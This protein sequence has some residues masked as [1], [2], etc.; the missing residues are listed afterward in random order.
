[1]AKL[2]SSKS[3]G[4]PSR[5]NPGDVYFTVDTGNVYLALGDG[6]LFNVNDLMAGGGA[7]RVVGPQGE[8]GPRGEAGPKGETGERGPAGRDGRQGPQGPKG[9]TG[10]DAPRPQVEAFRGPRGDQ[11]PAGKDGDP[12]PEVAALNNKLD[13]LAATVKALLD[14]DAYA[15]EY[16]EWLKARAAARR[17]Q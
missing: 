8:A 14:K 5:G 17:L 9:E 4:L 6:T 2:F 16:V 1:M 12:G 3:S 7:A 10:A 13:S 11:G 15:S